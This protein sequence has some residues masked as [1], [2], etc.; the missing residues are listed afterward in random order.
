MTHYQG[1]QPGNGVHGGQAPYF[2]A[3]VYHPYTTVEV[4]GGAI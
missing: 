2:A 1:T 4:L 3:G